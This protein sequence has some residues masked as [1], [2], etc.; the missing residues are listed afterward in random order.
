MRKIKTGSMLC[1]IREQKK[2]SQKK[3]CAGVCSVATLSKYECGERT[4]D[5]LLF[6]FFMQ[7]MG[8]APDDFAVMLSDEEFQYYKWKE[9]IFTAIQSGEWATV[10]ELFHS[11]EAENRDCNSKIQNQFYFYVSAVYAEKI[12]KNQK[13][14]VQFLE[15]AVRETVPD[16]LESRLTE[17]Q[18]STMEIGLMAIY[19]YKGGQQ[20]FIESNEIYR[21][22]YSLLSY[23]REEIYDKREASRLIPGIACILLKCCGNQMNVWE[24]LAIEEE[25]VRLLKENRKMYHLPEILRF[26][27]RDLA[28]TDAEKAGVYEKQYQAFLE[29]YQDTGYGTCFQP[30][31]IFDSQEQVYLLD[32]YMHSYRDISGM[33]QEQ[34]SDGICAPETYSRLET[35]KRKPHPKQREA[36]VERLEI[37]WGYFR[38]D[39][40]TTDYKVFELLNQYREEA[41]K[42]R[43]KEA[44]IYANELKSK[45]DMESINNR[46]YMGMI[47][48]H[49]AYAT[50][51]ISAEEICRRDRELLELSVTEERLEKTEMY[52]FSHIEIILHIHIANVLCD[53]GKTKEAI[54]F[55]E[56]VLKKT[57]K[58]A[59][60]IEYWWN[61][62]NAVVFNLANMRS[63]MGDYVT[64]LKDMKDFTGKCM[65]MY[66]GR[67]LACAI[68]EIAF[69]L[70]HLNKTNQKVSKRLLEQAFYLTDFYEMS[71]QHNNI[72][73]YYKEH[74]D[75]EKE[76]YGN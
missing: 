7:R 8:M 63:D 21:N 27:V 13:K 48:N 69:D 19:F 65:R 29:V 20:N 76:W 55:L 34:V 38:G 58:S 42:N 3:L 33:T 23:V 6:F 62:M 1:Q 5:G 72:Q 70:E 37:G 64:S 73:K 31:Q 50:G 41:A 54:G 24:R 49:I 45:M 52:Y 60:G 36:I 67:F 46:Q 74:Y 44:E 17:Y 30:E 53:M 2:I 10:E 12:E 75:K 56:R 66:D 15:K 25:A 43:W 68:G 71:G 51:R 32:E 40:E 11:M 61:G 16:F 4:P 9:A 14:A 22:Q 26:Y 35:G 57:E 28:E 39:L 47:E 59:V 18:L